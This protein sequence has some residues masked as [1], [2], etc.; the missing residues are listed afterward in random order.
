MRRGALSWVGRLLIRAEVV[1]VYVF[2]YLPIL[3]IIV[4]SFHEDAVMT[5]P[6][7]SISAHWYR[8]FLADEWLHA[9]IIN[10]VVLG[11][12]AAIVSGVLGT[13]CALGLVRCR[14]RGRSVVERMM[15]APMLIPRVILGTALLSFLHTLR[16]P[17]GFAYLVIGHVL[18]ALPYVILV[19]AAALYGF[20][21]ELEESAL[22][23]GANEIQ[24]FLSV[25]LPLLMPTVVAAM[26][27][28]F[29]I[30]FQDYEA[31]QAWADS[32]SITLPISIFTKIR[33]ELTP[34]V[35]VVAV[36]FV[37]VGVIV[38]SCGEW[39]LRRFRF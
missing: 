39:I 12:V 18:I 23:L 30:S 21:R 24:T 5:F 10:S 22:S 17:R 36:L 31:S 16:L 34:E 15:L 4:M 38:P 27:F 35:N 26:L 32:R 29:T 6:P 11:V 9:A 8:E 33:E 7:P 20:R 28:A 3:L 19:V 1:S 14:F 2:L 13:L 25:T 37:L